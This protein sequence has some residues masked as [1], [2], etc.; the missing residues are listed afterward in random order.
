MYL[1]PKLLL[2][3]VRFGASG[4]CLHDPYHLYIWM[5][6]AIGVS[7]NSRVEGFGSIKVAALRLN[8]AARTLRL[9]F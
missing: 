3:A 9:G 1:Y 8:S 4:D 6:N 7:D 2:D 5:R